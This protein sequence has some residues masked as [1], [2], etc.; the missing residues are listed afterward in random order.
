MRRVYP[1]E[2]DI[3]ILQF[4]SEGEYVYIDH[5]FCPCTEIFPFTSSFCP[6]EVV[7]IPTFVAL[8]N[9]DPVPRVVAEVQRHT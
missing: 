2:F 9:I 8:S 7:P 6:G 4:T 3:P 1:G 5:P